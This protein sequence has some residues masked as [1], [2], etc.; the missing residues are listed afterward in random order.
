MRRWTTCK[1]T[2]RRPRH[3]KALCRSGPMCGSLLNLPRVSSPDTDLYKRND[4]KTKQNSNLKSSIS[5]IMFLSLLWIL[6]GL[7]WDWNIWTIAITYPM[8]VRCDDFYCN[9]LLTCRISGHTGEASC[10]SS[11]CRLLQQ[12][13]DNMYEN[14]IRTHQSVLY[15]LQVSSKLSH[16]PPLQQSHFFFL[17]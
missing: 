15:K 13:M 6:V 10:Q 17:I 3:C 7:V 4:K 12:C 16:P 2:R 1:L 14:I 9:A 5:S 8:P 11:S